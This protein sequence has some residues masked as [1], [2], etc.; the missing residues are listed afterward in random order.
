L[1]DNLNDM[2]L[3][4][5]REDE[6]GLALTR[7]WLENFFIGVHTENNRTV[8]VEPFSLLDGMGQ[9]LWQGACPCACQCEYDY[10]GYPC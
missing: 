1:L 2:R 4:R 8:M 5:Y 7:M 6:M 3:A 10:Q 9:L